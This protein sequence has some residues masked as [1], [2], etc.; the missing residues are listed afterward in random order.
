MKPPEQLPLPFR[1]RPAFAI[2]FIEAPSNAAAL[3]WL[4]RTQSWPD[5]RLALWGAA[6]CGK[7]HLLHLWAGANGAQVVAGPALTEPRRTTGQAIDEADAVA[8]EAVLLHTLNVAAEVGRPVLIAAR[9]PPARW[10][11]QLAD[12][13][14]RLR[15]ITA[16]Q[17][18]PAE[19]SLLQALLARLLAERQIAIPPATR[20][21]LL[22]HLPRA[23]AAV[24]EAV[25]RLDSASLEAGARVTPAFA[26]RVLDDLL[27]WSPGPATYQ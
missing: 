25:D 16:V 27:D 12:L 13:A 10:T 23:P 2:D 1:H 19:D 21:W 8:D 4:A 26:K 17:I 11:T 24:R 22:L 6:G 20:D 15:A 3:G 18:G 14:S 5:G 7:T 9:L